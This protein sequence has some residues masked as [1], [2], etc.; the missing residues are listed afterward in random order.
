M[1]AALDAF[2]ARLSALYADRLAVEKAVLTEELKILEHE[3]RLRRFQQL[4]EKEVEMK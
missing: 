4:E 2:D 3:K 1:V